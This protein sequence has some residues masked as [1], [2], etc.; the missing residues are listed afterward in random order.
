[1][2]D[3]R[4]L[5]PEPTQPLPAAAPTPAL[6]RT[7]WQDEI[8]EPKALARQTLEALRTYRAAEV[9]MRRRTR[10][11]MSMAEDE[12]LALRFLLRRA[13]RTARPAELAHY[14]GITTADTNA[15]A[16][17]LQ[18]DGRVE[19]VAGFAINRSA[20]IR[21]TDTADAEVRDTLNGMHLR[22]YAAAMKLTPSQHRHITGFLAAMTDAI[23]SVDP[24]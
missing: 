2:T 19:R 8:S 16:D 10:E 9:A 7:Y 24:R 17:K 5:D 11:A 20:S 1:M 3:A 21:A 15:L 14:L 22:M 12:M 23:D 4:P 13:D 18:R 6:P